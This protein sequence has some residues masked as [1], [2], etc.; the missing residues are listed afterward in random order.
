MEID[1]LEWRA[2]LTRVTLAQPLIID[3]LFNALEPFQ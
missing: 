2:F 1:P 3:I